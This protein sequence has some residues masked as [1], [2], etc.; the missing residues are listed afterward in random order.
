MA[1]TDGDE[2]AE[3]LKFRFGTGGEVFVFI[4]SQNGHLIAL[5][6]DSTG[7]NLPGSYGP[8]HPARASAL[9][10]LTRLAEGLLLN[11]IMLAME[12]RGYYLARS[13]GLPW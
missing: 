8:W 6:K 11:A 3:A 4:S 9:R 13:D 2:V 1:T 10:T 12:T 5:A 7:S